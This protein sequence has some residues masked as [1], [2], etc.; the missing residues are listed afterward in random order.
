MYSHQKPVAIQYKGAKII[1]TDYW[2]T[3][4]AQKGYVFITF[5]G[6][7]FHLLVPDSRSDFF[8]EM[9][10]G[11]EVLIS[12]G[13]WLDAGRS[14]GLELM[15]ED[16]SDD[17]FCLHISKEQAGQF[18]NENDVD[19]EVNS[20]DEVPAMNLVVYGEEGKVLELPA[21][22]RIVSTIPYRQMWLD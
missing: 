16:Y 17:P 9:K 11:M 3:E 12:R 5:E 20:Y 10:T 21:R 8:E 7:N 22:Y 14:Y 19:L 1:E 18:S 2:K 6:N 4:M 13:R 15:F